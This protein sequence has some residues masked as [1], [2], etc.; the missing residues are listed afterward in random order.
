[1]ATD[2]DL[3]SP[4]GYI[5]FDINP[6]EYNPSIADT[7]IMLHV[8][9]SGNLEFT[10]GNVM[11]MYES[12]VPKIIT[13]VGYHYEYDFVSGNKRIW[14]VII[15]EDVEGNHDIYHYR[16]YAIETPI[17]LQSPVAIDTSLTNWR[18]MSQSVI[19]SSLGLAASV[20]GT[21]ATGGA[22]LPA[23]I[24]AGANSLNTI[25]NV[26][27]EKYNERCGGYSQVG[28]VGG[29]SEW[30]EAPYITIYQH[31][32]IN[33]GD[34]QA[35]WGKPDFKNRNV[36]SIATAN[37][38][39]YQTQGCQLNQNGLPIQIIQE[40]QRLADNGFITQ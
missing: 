17:K 33:L 36:E 22:M 34:I 38:G 18:A 14:P 6:I 30:R 5:Y 9:D 2:R 27:Q 1:M 12:N 25:N 26:Q 10:L 37:P 28:S 21:V 11:G 23:A 31:K 29:S 40:A 13:N 32:P 19:A 16:E 20:A 24:A 3:Q 35:K 8:P 39:Y 15:V 4:G 7:Q